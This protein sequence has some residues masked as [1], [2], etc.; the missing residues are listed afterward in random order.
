M[1]TF[2]F[3]LMES[4]FESDERT[5]RLKAIKELDAAIGIVWKQMRLRWT[6][7]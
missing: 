5:R 3:S 1:V 4:G 2:K 6:S 7:F